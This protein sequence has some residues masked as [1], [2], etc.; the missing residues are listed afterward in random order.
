MIVAFGLKVA[1]VLIQKALTKKKQLPPASLRKKKARLLQLLV[2]T[3]R[4]QND[5]MQTPTYLIHHQ[6]KQVHA[7]AKVL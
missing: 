5:V 3:I 7:V 1:V 4:Q 6:K 2:G